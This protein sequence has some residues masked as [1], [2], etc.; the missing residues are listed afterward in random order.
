[1]KKIYLVLMGVAALSFATLSCSKE[2]ADPSLQEQNQ[3][4]EPVKDEPAKE[5]PS[6]D[7]PVP[8]GMI[9]LTFGVS[10]EGDAS[11]NEGDDT[12]TTWDGTTH[13]WSDGD[14]I[15]IIVGEGNVE[16]TDYVDAEV[17]DGKVTAVV[18]D[19][20]YYYAVYPTTAT[21]TFTAAEGKITITIPRY[22]KGTFSE[23]NIMAAKTSKAAAT[24]N[25]KNMTSIVKLTTGNKF[26]YNTIAV[27]ANDQTKL[28]GTVSTTFG[29]PFAVETT[30]GSDA[31]LSLQKGN[32]SGYAGV[33]ANTT[34]YLAMLP[35]EDV[36]NGIGFKIEQRA[37]DTDLIAGGISK[38]AFSRE[39]AKVYDMGTLDDRIVTDWYISE[40]GTGVGNVESAPASPARLMDLLNPSYSTNNTTAGWRLVGATIHVLPGTYNL[41]ELN[42]GEVFDPHYNLSNLKVH[43]K[44]EG[45]ALNPTKFIC[46][47]TADDEH[48]FAVTGSHKVGN[49]TFEN[50]TFTANPSASNTNSSGIAFNYSGTADVENTIT[51]K[52]C[53]FEGL[54]NTASGTT[55]GGSAVFVYSSKDFDI[56]FDGCSFSNNNSSRAAVAL[57]NTGENGNVSFTGCTFSNNVT[58]NNG[59]SIYVYE[60]GKATVDHSSF[61][62]DGST[63]MANNGGAITVIKNASVVLQNGCTIDGCV[64]KGNGGAIFNHGNVVIDNSTISNCVGKVGGAIYSDGTVTIKNNSIISGNNMYS[65][66]TNGGAIYLIYGSNGSSAPALDIENSSIVSNSSTNG[67]AI[68]G[69]KGDASHFV[70]TRVFNT[71]FKSNA[72]SGG[73]TSGANRNGGCIYA[74]DYNYL[75]FANCTFSDNTVGAG[76]IIS[77]GRTGD[78]DYNKVYLVSSTIDG[79][80][81]G[82]QRN[83]K[84][85]VVYNSIVIGNK[86]NTAQNLSINN[87]IWGTGNQLNIYGA[88]ALQGN[89]NYSNTATSE[90]IEFSLGTY[91]DG[92]Y[93]LKSTYSSR[94]TQG[95]T[96]AA[97]QE[98]TFDNI[99]LTDEQKALLAKDQKGNNRAGTIMGAY[100]LTE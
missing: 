21:Y 45:T 81:D 27:M 43:V 37:A 28:T 71:L 24:L 95:M 42:G 59:G 64:S 11:A 72:A 67:A 96:A 54:T 32:P 46:N 44:G 41:Q 55:Y 86:T 25:F 53:V 89:G 10:Q 47:Q 40:S 9:R 74:T 50:I 92:V 73:A 15:R 93:P 88:S 61:V 22:Q 36:D 85:N 66:G 98:L 97:I 38:S 35:G 13:G 2:V 16:N 77:M 14:Q 26:S 65:G 62:G 63:S 4:E 6:G 99:T 12:K 90:N 76:G 18:P 29:E 84:V 87:S 57:C 68:Y 39:R 49:F 17:I 1:M 58:T 31:I 23:A 52:N 91:D 83:S 69:G 3:K 100:V 94:Y 20:D 7:T 78:V 82:I 30:N 33:S 8:E 51:F 80:N 48:I 79:A 56:L 70:V 34:Y 5:D 60:G 75:L 19:A